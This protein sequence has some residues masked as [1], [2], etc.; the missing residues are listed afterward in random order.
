MEQYGN[1]QVNASRFKQIVKIAYRQFGF[2][3]VLQ[4][5]NKGVPLLTVRDFL[6]KPGNSGIGIGATLASIRFNATF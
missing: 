2:L 1:I 5:L 6:C 4:E 3:C